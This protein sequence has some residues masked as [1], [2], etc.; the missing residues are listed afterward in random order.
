[1]EIIL[2]ALLSSLWS[3]LLVDYFDPYKFILNKLGLYYKNVYNEE[4]KK[5]EQVR[6]WTS[7]N[8]WLDYI[9]YFITKLF[10]CALCLSYWIFSFS[11]LILCSSFMGFIFGVVIY[12]L[13]M[14]IQ[15]IIIKYVE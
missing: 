4:M 3:I 10:N 15:K 2:I 7:F 5:I 1:M 11:I 9:F 8:P 12:F 13:T 14:L 6:N